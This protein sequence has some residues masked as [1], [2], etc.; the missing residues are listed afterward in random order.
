MIRK[1]IEI[2]KSPMTDPRRASVTG[3][4]LCSGIVT[5]NEFAFGHIAK[6]GAENNNDAGQACETDEGEADVR[7]RED[8]PG[9]HSFFV[10]VVIVACCGGF[11]KGGFPHRAV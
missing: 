6:C 11:G 10:T 2:V 4:R 7:A 8:G 1:G 5:E 9:F 3:L